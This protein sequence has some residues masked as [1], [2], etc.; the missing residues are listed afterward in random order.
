M[1]D[2][3]SQIQSLHNASLRLEYLSTAGPRIVGL[4]LSGSSRNL[5]AETPDIHWDTPYGK[6]SLGGGHRLWIAP[7]NP[8]ITA[9]PDDSGLVVQELKTGVRLTQPADPHTLITRSIEIHLDDSRP[10]VHLL[11][12][13]T[14]ESRALVRFSA[15]AITQL[16]LGGTAILPQA[17]DSL[18]AARLLPNRNL[19]L[20]S[21]TRWDD[22]RLLLSDNGYY[23]HGS[24]NPTP[25]KIGY[26]NR[27]GWLAY[28]QEGV[29]F[30]KKYAVLP[31]L[32][33]P[34]MGCNVEAYVKDRFIELETLS[35]MTNL[36][37][38]ESIKHAEEWHVQAIF[39]SPRNLQEI[40]EIISQIAAST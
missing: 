35:P 2:P 27:L 18:D 26:F 24:P 22:P 1:A 10:V 33:F 25:C 29:V 31:P 37:P 21:Y 16:P 23:L 20:W 17:M 9:I 30:L 15:W 19:V 28:F 36:H 12:T 34:D 6:Y 11:H 4:Y 7:E 32:D 5:L 8:N 14:N 3:R 38:G 40:L 39:A 13:L